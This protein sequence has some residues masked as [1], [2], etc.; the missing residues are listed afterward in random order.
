MI[1]MTVQ[2]HLELH[3]YEELHRPVP[4]KCPP[5]SFPPHAAHSPAF[6]PT[7][8]LFVTHKLV[9]SPPPVSLSYGSGERC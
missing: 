2:I 7:F 6:Q 4:S 3:I 5:V 9:S 1:F 8:P